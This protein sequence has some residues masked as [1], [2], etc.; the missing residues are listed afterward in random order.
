MRYQGRITTWKDDRGFGFITPDGSG[1]EAFVHISS[2]S[3]RQRRPVGNDVVSY[4]RHVDEQ[5]RIQAKNVVFAG[6][7]IPISRRGSK[8]A[9]L[10]VDFLCAFVAAV[11]VGFL[12][13]VVVII[14]LVASVVAFC[15]YAIDKAAA[16]RDARRIPERTLHLI[17]LL[18]GWPGALVAQRIFRHKTIKA[19]FQRMFWITVVLNCVAVGWLLSPSGAAV[20]LGVFSSGD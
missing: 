3:N 18:G 13:P 10:A 7:Q 8:R 14:Y 11:F 15:A 6:E 20:R 17:A 5:G 4:E 2:F 12:P 19:S 16:R 9:V 1:E